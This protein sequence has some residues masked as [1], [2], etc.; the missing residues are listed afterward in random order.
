MSQ[1]EAVAPTGVTLR[2]TKI[3]E[4]R[5]RKSYFLGVGMDARP[6]TGA[7]SIVGGGD[8]GA[9]LIFARG[10]TPAQVVA[11]RFG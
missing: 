9:A 4:I 6:P 10:A 7:A 8:A 1:G 2:P 5:W 11:G 3:G